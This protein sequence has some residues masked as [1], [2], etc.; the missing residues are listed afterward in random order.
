MQ[1]QKLYGLWYIFEQLSIITKLGWKNWSK[2]A[3]PKFSS[4][5]VILRNISEPTHKL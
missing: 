3:T 4:M 5:N 1:D 2:V